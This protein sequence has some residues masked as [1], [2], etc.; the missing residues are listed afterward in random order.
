MI[1]RSLCV[2]ARTAEVPGVVAAEFL[3]AL[4]GALHGGGEGVGGGG[5][6]G[7]LSVV[8]F[9]LGRVGVSKGRMQGSR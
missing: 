2:G 7:E 6:G 9:K 5:E 8:I 3:V 4:Y 1:S